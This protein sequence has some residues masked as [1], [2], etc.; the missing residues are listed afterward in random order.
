MH[1]V[2]KVRLQRYTLFQIFVSYNIWLPLCVNR[3]LFIWSPWNLLECSRIFFWHNTMEPSVT[4]PTTRCISLM[5]KP[6]K[7]VWMSKTW[8]QWFM[9]GHKSVPMCSRLLGKN[10]IFPQWYLFYFTLIF[11]TKFVHRINF[12]KFTLLSKKI[13]FCR[14]ILYCGNFL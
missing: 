12:W 13:L 1:D 7:Q 6:F 4:H 9:F 10:T 3:H 11:S 5:L 8:C 2:K 14:G